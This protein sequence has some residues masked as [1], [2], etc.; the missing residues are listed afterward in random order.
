MRTTTA[1]LVASFALPAWFWAGCA[2]DEVEIGVVGMLD[3]QGRV[4]RIET[5][6]RYSALDATLL[7]QLAGAHAKVAAENDYYLYRVVYPTADVH[8]GTTTVSGL[9]AV[10]ATRDIKG[11]VSWQHG[12]NTYRPESISE[13]SLPEGL[14]TA[15]VFGGDGYI[16]VAADYIGLGVS[17]EPQAY[18]DWPSTVST[19]TDLISIAAIMLDGI[20]RAPRPDLYLAG[21]SQ[22]GGA[23]AALQAALEQNNPTG[24]QL[25]GAV[26]IS[27]AFNPLSIS[28]PHVIAS[29]D[30]LSMAFFATSFS[31]LYG[32]PLSDMV[33]AP[34]DSLLPSWFDG[35]K[36]QDFLSA[37]LPA[38]V[39]QLVTTSFLGDFEAG[40]QAPPW[41]YGGLTAAVTSDYAPRAPLRIY[42]GDED[43]V[44]IPEEALSA[45]NRMQGLGGEVELVDVGAYNHD[46]VVVAALPTIQQWFDAVAGQAP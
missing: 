34:Y 35:T 26:A 25:R 13:P 33:Q 22:G 20:A 2:R 38:R 42:Y 5:L 29:N 46:D 11:V 28:L 21:F 4:E 1:C 18:Y 36:D 40:V 19:V 27:A 41:F 31:Q 43:T 7:F 44:V 37:N 23:T 14:G 17:T 39:D 8:D 9:V 3:Y 15:A 32:Q 24:L 12:T 16:M 10:P 30:T 6:G 45:F